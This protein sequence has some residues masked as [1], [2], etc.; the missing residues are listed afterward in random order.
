MQTLHLLPWLLLLLPRPLAAAIPTPTRYQPSELVHAG[1]HVLQRY[2]SPRHNTV[3]IMELSRSGDVLRH[4]R[5]VITYLLHQLGQQVAV[6]LLHNTP[7]EDPHDQILFL[8]DSAKAFRT[9]RFHFAKSLFDR[10][11]YFLILLTQ[12]E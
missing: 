1:L 11:F 10:E 6:Q 2:V 9:L 4:H 5:L 3:A 8:V 7:I 12:G